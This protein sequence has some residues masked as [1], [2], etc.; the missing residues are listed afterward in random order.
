TDPVRVSAIETSANLFQVLGVSP[1]LGPGFPKDGPFFSRD[2]IAVISDRL[3]RERY[4]ADP[5][6]VGRLLDLKDGRYA[7]AGVMP[8][9]FNFPDDVDV[10][11]RLNWDLTQHSRSAHF[12]EAVARL[13]SGVTLDRTSQELASLSGRLAAQT[14]ATNRGWL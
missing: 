3:W 4:E 7:I 10:W 5:A 13:R 11:L 2:P 1:Q 9:G 6:I 12:M 14:P 8:P